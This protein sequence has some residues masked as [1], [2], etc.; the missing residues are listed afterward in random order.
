MDIGPPEWII[1]GIVLLLI[2]GSSKIP[3][4]ARNLGKAQSELKKGLA[5][6]RGEDPD[7]APA[8]AVT[9]AAAPAP[10]PAPAPLPEPQTTAGGTPA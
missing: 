7:A 3:Q 10:A 9:Q 1:I 8:P 2:F 5:E 4:I 6:G